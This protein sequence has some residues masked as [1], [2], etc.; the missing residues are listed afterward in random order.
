MRILSGMQPSGDV[1]LGNYLGALRQWVH[2]QG[3]ESFY[4]VVDLH[5]L[6]LEI[7]PDVLH[8]QT[9]NLFATLIAIGIDPDVSTVFVQSHVPYHA[10]LN[11]LLECV[12]SYGELSRMV[13]FKEKSERQEG[14]RVGLLTYPVLMVADILLYGATHVPVGDDQRQHLEITR[15]VAERFNHRYG[16]TFI[17]PVGVQPRVA[18]RVMDLQVPTRKMSKSVSSPLGTIYLYDEPADIERKIMKAV[19]DT[20]GEMRFDWEHKPGLAN[21]LEI[22]ASFSEESPQDVAARFTRYGDFKKELAELL[23]ASL[24]PVRERYREVRADEARLRS[25]M[26][27]G[28]RKAIA[29]AEPVYERAAR[30]MGLLQI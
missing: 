23:V 19:T 11:W 17:V 20:D 13:A 9:L 28:A 14:Y 29:V 12:T 1:H 16:E 4:C 6:T 3:P 2:G 26:V 30:A 24:S 5:A 18:A 15:D 25:Q 21:L 22:Y 8:E 27:S 10:Q 7:A